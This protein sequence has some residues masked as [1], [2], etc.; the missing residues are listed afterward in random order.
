MI[1]NPE[2]GFLNFGNQIK[3]PAVSCIPPK[4][5]HTKE[6]MLC[7]SEHGGSI[8]GKNLSIPIIKNKTLH[9]PVNNFIRFIG[10]SLMKLSDD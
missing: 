4:V 1:K 2:T 9:I 3:T 7:I 6:G 5:I 10:L 8:K